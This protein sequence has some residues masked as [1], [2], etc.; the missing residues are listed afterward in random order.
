MA[1]SQTDEALER[2][3][4]EKSAAYIACSDDWSTEPFDEGY[5]SVPYIREDVVERM[6]AEAVEAREEM[7]RYAR[8]E[9]TD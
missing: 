6:I 9:E 7:L 3:W 8:D 2:I 4:V 5:E 1:I